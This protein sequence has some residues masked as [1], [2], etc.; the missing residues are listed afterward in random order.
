MN[1]REKSD[2][3]WYTVL[4]R[5]WKEVFVIYLFFVI[6]KGLGEGNSSSKCIK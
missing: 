3:D 1:A 2:T 4:G 6:V 5:G